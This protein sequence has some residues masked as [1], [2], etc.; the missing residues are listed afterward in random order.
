MG[1]SI[2]ADQP[3]SSR[4]RV[5]AA[6]LGRLFPGNARTSSVVVA[7][8][9]RLGPVV[10]VP[11]PDGDAVIRSASVS[12]GCARHQDLKQ[13]SL[14]PNLDS[15]TIR[16]PI[17]PETRPPEDEWVDHHHTRAVLRFHRFALGGDELVVDQLIEDRPRSLSPA[18]FERFQQRHVRAPARVTEAARLQQVCD[19]LPERDVTHFSRKALLHIDAEIPVWGILGGRSGFL[20]ASGHD[21]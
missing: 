5:V 10:T 21:A 20:L 19:Q 7:E 6:L 9:A 8:P 12:V 11:I 16:D 18:A 2:G 13:V 14:H 1:Q 4:T 15:E 17:R 3:E